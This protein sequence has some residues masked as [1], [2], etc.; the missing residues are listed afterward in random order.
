MA[1]SPIDREDGSGSE[2]Y[3]VEPLATSR[4]RRSTAGRLMSTLL[5]AEADDE[6]ARIFAEEEDDEEFESGDDEEEGGGAAADDMELDSSSSDEGDQ[7]PAATGNDE[8]EGEK[9]LERQE[10]AERAKKRT[11]QQEGF[12]MPA[13]RKKK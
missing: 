7:G 6:L 10:K 8:L 3:H 11:A 5:D 4:A 1:E 12:R 13:L 2:S 9:E